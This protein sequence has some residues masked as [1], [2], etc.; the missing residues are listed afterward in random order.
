MPPS[1]SYL[2]IT[3]SDRRKYPSRWDIFTRQALD[4]K[5]ELRCA[6]LYADVLGV[7]AEGCSQ[8]AVLKRQCCFYDVGGRER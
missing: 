3:D 7:Q 6:N 2:Q 4:R 8:A 1:L 5:L